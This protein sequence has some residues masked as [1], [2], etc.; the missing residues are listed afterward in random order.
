M[1]L[2]EL[3]NNFEILISKIEADGEKNAAFKLRQYRSF[4]RILKKYPYEDLLKNRDD[5]F[6]YLEENGKKKT[7]SIVKKIKEY[8]DTGV[9]AAVEDAKNDPKIKCV[10]ELTKVYAIGPKK[11][12]KL[13]KEHDICTIDELRELFKKDN[14]VLHNKQKLG[15]KYF[16]DLEKR[17]PRK[18]MEM[19]DKELKKICKKISKEMKFS[20]NGS[21]RRKLKTSGDIDVLISG[22]EDKVKDFR[23]SFI[24]ELKNKKIIVADLASGNK[25][26]MGVVKLNKCP[27]RH[28]DIIDTN[29]EEY[30]FAVLYFTGS[31]GFNTIMRAKALSLGYSMNEY[32]LTDKKTKKPLDK[33]IIKSKIGK[34]SFETEKDI[35]KFLDMKYLKP[36]ERNHNTPSKN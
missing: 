10:R 35:F 2:K 17:I 33:K 21:Y 9:I 12:L 25:K 8:L 24:E 14:T 22:P 19:Y 3:V 4:V 18:E 32:T 13:Y 15:L 6:E 29:L 20:I 7:S 26:Y 31:G 5:L 16:D 23:Q 36:E 1:S 30:P 34:E 11:A 28:M 27:H